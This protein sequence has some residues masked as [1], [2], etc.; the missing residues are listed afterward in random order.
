MLSPRRDLHLAQAD[1]PLE[2]DQV[3]MIG[4]LHRLV[5]SEEQVLS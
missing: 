3:A 2:I 1:G 5:V 4:N